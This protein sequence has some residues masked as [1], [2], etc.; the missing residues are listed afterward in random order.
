[1]ATVEKSDFDLIQ[2]HE[3]LKEE[4]RFISDE[5]NFESHSN[6]AIQ[7]EILQFY[8][9]KLNKLKNDSNYY[10]SSHFCIRSFLDKCF[11]NFSQQFLNLLN[12]RRV[13]LFYQAR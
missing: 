7:Q 10:E 8:E 5:T 2:E 13:K 1:M 12:G 9:P 11:Y 6:I 4:L 3:A